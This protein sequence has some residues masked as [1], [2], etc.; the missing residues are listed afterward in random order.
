MYP[1]I[2]GYFKRLLYLSWSSE[3]LYSF[4]TRIGHL[5]SHVTSFHP[6]NTFSLNPSS[7]LVHFAWFHPCL[8]LAHSLALFPSLRISVSAAFLLVL[9]SCMHFIDT[10]SHAATFVSIV[11][12][13]HWLCAITGCLFHC[14]LLHWRKVMSISH[15]WEWPQLLHVSIG[16]LFHTPKRRQ[17]TSNMPRGARNV[18][19]MLQPSLKPDL[20]CVSYILL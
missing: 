5:L 16:E 9:L 14:V 7:Q 18:Q 2:T 20:H 11:S 6:C 15:G 1:C 10:H 19:V 17:S 12:Y 13:L 4:F 8:S 3:M